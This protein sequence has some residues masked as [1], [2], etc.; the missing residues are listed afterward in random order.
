MRKDPVA[1]TDVLRAVEL[2]GPQARPYDFDDY[3]GVV[4]G[5]FD[6]L[7]EG[8]ETDEQL[9]GPGDPEEQNW[10]PVFTAPAKGPQRG[11]AR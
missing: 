11:C 3:W 7:D 10:A 5:V 2:F 4:R 9:R 8:V 6:H 1:P